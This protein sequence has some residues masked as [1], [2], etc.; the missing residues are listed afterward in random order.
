MSIQEGLPQRVTGGVRSRGGTENS[1]PVVPLVSVVTVV[2]N[3]AA[4]LTQCIESVLTQSWPGIEYIIIDGGSTDA[5]LD[6]IRTYD[7]RLAFWVSEPDQGIFDAMNKGIGLATGELIGLL[8][9]DDWYE[10]GAVEAA[11]TALLE[12]GLR[13]V[14]Y[15]DKY[16]VQVDMGRVYEM[17]ASLEFWRGMNVCHQAMFVHREVYERLGGYDLRYRLAADFD[18]L[19]RAL[20]G[21]I[22]F[23]RLGRFVVNFRD[24]GASAQAL[25]EGNREISA[26]L[27]STYGAISTIYVK[28]RLLTGYNLAA[29]AVGRFIRRLLGERALNLCRIP[30]YRLFTR[31]GEEVRK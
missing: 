5:T 13:G 24:T 31:R 26:I 20:R 11:A 22:P 7:D 16:L 25:G 4:H 18:F 19:V 17:P 1:Q 29:V 8:N 6:I 9:A 15:G 30:F 28:N 3:G 2:K 27:R 14:Y 23:V 21:A 10:P 12:R